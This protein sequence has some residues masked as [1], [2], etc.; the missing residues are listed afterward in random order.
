MKTVL[1]M[2]ETI[3]PTLTENYQKVSPM[4]STKRAQKALYDLHNLPKTTESTEN[5]MVIF[6]LVIIGNSP[7]API[8]GHNFEDFG[9]KWKFDFFCLIII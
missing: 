2:L 5:L 4:G 9:L 6:T 1:N 7:A 8:T 3:L